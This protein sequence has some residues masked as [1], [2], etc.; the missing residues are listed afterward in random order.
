MGSEKENGGECL[1]TL[2]PLGKEL[3]RGGI[4]GSQ[5][6]PEP[7]PCQH[8]PAGRGKGRDSSWLQQVNM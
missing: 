6:L 4:W 7:S 5:A 2:D 1:G 3:G 8:F